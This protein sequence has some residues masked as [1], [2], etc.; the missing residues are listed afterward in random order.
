M[1]KASILA[2]STSKPAVILIL[3]LVW[4][5]GWAIAQ[6]DGREK[7][8]SFLVNVENDEFQM[9]DTD[10]NYTAG[11]LLMNTCRF[12]KG[13]LEKEKPLSPLVHDLNKAVSSWSPLSKHEYVQ[14]SGYF[15]FLLFTP[16]DFEKPK[17]TKGDGRPYASLFYIGDSK[18][19]VDGK[20]GKTFKQDIQLGLLGMSL[21]GK[22]QKEV[23]RFI[24][25]DIPQGWPTQISNGGEPTFLYALQETNLWLG[26]DDSN[27]ST[28]LDLVTT[29]GFTV[30]YYNSLQASLAA[31]FGRI[32]LPFWASYGPIFMRTP[33]AQR[34]EGDDPFSPTQNSGRKNRGAPSPTQSSRPQ[35]GNGKKNDDSKLALD[36]AYLFLAGG[37][38][39]VA[40]S[41]LLQGQFRSNDYEF[42]S[43]DVER[44]VPHAV[45]GIVL[46]LGRLQLS[47]SHTI[48]EREIRGGKNHSWGQISI[49]F[50][51]D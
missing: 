4:S 40:Y 49:A 39:L 3:F 28:K 13:N 25:S 32:T 10:E 20:K 16:N 31:R 17:P 21:G 11:H 8:C 46:Q 48:R 18:V 51:Y 33:S 24:G 42:E 43:S 37:V 44:L 14:N 45:I 22:I 50:F 38:D 36:E 27:R 29:H 15:G 47:Y 26:G 41:A 12:E 30:G 35:N 2:T 7:I 9:I 23:H 19:F 6:T 5:S 1:S 34:V